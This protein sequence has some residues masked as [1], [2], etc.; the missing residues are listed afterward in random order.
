MTIK[1]ND[2]EEQTA[3]LVYGSRCLSLNIL[4]ELPDNIARGI[5]FTDVI[6]RFVREDRPSTAG[7]DRAAELSGR[8]PD[9]LGEVRVRRVVERKRVCR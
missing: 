1:Q 4:S 2:T 8:L 5:V 3:L 6:L 9:N 7:C